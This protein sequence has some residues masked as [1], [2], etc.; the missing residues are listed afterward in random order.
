MSILY[1][2]LF[3]IGKLADKGGLLHSCYIH[4]WHWQVHRCSGEGQDLRLQGRQLATL[5]GSPKPGGLY[6]KIQIQI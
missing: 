5:S 2:Y 6:L 1:L 4:T 3:G